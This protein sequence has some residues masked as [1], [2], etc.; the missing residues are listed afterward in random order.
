M[1]TI[2]RFEDIEAWKKGRELRKV[3]YTCTKV[4]AFA[5]DF[6]LRSQIRRAAMSITA[7][8]AEGF[9]RGGNKDLSNSW[10][11][12]KVRVEKSAINYTWLWT[13]CMFRT[14]NLINFLKMQLRSADLSQAL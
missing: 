11:R 1:A 12:R 6:E 2:E 8:I 10:Q 14:S 13:N 3:I 4:G 5:K 7:N 9:E